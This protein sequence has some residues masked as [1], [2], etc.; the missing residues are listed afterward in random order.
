MERVRCRMFMC[1]IHSFHI[2]DLFKSLVLILQE[3]V[4]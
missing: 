1:D 3:A 4:I 2:R